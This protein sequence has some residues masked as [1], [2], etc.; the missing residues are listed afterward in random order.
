MTA[1]HI[2]L[3]IGW[4]FVV[5]VGI[6]LFAKN[7][8]IASQTISRWRRG[9]ILRDGRQITAVVLSKKYDGGPTAMRRAP[10]MTVECEID[11][12]RRILDQIVQDDAYFHYSP[13][14][15]IDVVVSKRMRFTPM[16][17]LK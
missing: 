2:G 3:G 5:A 15:R 16:I 11:G 17:S 12:Q 10:R 8:I 7:V 1:I 6:A 13:G 9:R 14:D 4:M